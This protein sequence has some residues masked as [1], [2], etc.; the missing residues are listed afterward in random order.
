MAKRQMVVLGIEKVVPDDESYNDELEESYLP[1]SH[2]HST[3]LDEEFEFVAS[4]AQFPYVNKLLEQGWRVVSVT[5]QTIGGKN[6]ATGRFLFVLE[7]G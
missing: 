5:P 3:Y 4:G 2:Y 7:K 1:P 6:S